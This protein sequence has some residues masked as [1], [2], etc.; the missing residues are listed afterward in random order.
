MA[1]AGVDEG[2]HFFDVAE[3]VRAGDEFAEFGVLAAR[4]H[5]ED[6]FDFA[7]GAG[8]VVVGFVGLAVVD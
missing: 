7:E 1:H 3:G 2:F 8:D 5:V 6:G 4:L